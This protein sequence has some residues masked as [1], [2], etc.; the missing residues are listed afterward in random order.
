MP[1]NQTPEQK[2]RENIDKMLNLS[3]WAVQDKDKIDF[4]TSL[5]VAIRGYP[6]DVGLADYI[7]FVDRVPVGVIEAKREEEGHRLTVHEDQAEY[8]AESKLKYVN[9]ETLSFV[10]E[11]T[12]E[13]T[14]FTNKRDPKPRSRP[15]F[16]FHRPGTLKR[17]LKQGKSLR[18]RLLDLPDLDPQG[19]E[20]ARSGQ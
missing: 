9:N 3:G 1:L 19:C 2:A 4:S 10:Y 7:L 12:S 15:V 16:S 20:T 5:G 18:A 11:S 17:W 6:T 13:V 14:R 8:Y